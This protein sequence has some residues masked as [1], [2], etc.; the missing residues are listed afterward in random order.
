MPEITASEWDNFLSSHT[1]A[2]LLQTSA[3]GML[4]A[5]F[6]WQPA[7]VFLPSTA[8]HPAG[9]QIL[10]RQLPV[11]AS[12]AYIP[13]GPVGS[14][15]QIGP[16]AWEELWPEID[17]VCRRRRA[18]F[19]KVE[20]DLWESP[21]GEAGCPANDGMDLFAVGLNGSPPAGFSQSIHAIQ[22]RRTL[23]VDLEGDEEQVLGRMKQK[24]RYNIRLASKKGITVHPSQDI[25]TFHRLMAV[26]G[27]RD[28]FGVHAPEYY[29]RA[30]DLFSRCGECVLLL[31]EY[32]GEP[33]AAIMVF[34]RGGRA[35][36]FYGASS[37]AHRERMPTYLLQWEGMR[38]AR[39]QGCQLYDLWGVPDA[40]EQTL[41]AN[42]S[43]R[44]DGLWGVYRF[45]RGFG[46]QL[47]RSLGPWDRVYNAPL[48][49]L[50]SWWMRSRQA[51]GE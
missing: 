5:G 24:T 26:T 30:F 43:D 33:L 7:Y 45:K 47:L 50:Y 14:A 10:F 3:W 51:Q 46:G 36:Y 37:N 35:W 20:P 23:V 27:E 38:W 42:F 44:S 41:E 12:L 32:E 25:E 16:S 17:R 13:K 6:G 1:G 15:R 8:K 39:E 19:L 34:A 31:A 49:G 29:R 11:G 22:P 2:H 48:Y 18:I 28:A 40:D 4:K 21:P 9:A